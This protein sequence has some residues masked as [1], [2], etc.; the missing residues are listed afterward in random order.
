M[1]TFQRKSRS[2]TRLPDNQVQALESRLRV[3]G[4][5]GGVWAV[6]VLGFEYLRM[7]S[8][9]SPYTLEIENFLFVSR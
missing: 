7:S 6:E 1:N 5:D 4:R 8:S 3:T 9:S 2:K